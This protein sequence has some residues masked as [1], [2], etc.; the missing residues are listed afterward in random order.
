MRSKLALS[1][2]TM[3][4]VEEIIYYDNLPRGR[5]NCLVQ[6]LKTGN[7]MQIVTTQLNF[8]RN[9]Y[10]KGLCTPEIGKLARRVVGSN[11]KRRI[12]SEQK[13]QLDIRIKKV[14]REL[15]QIKWSFKR[16]G[17]AVRRLLSREALLRYRKLKFE[18]MEK[19][20]VDESNAKKSKLKWFIKKQQLRDH[21]ATRGRE[22]DQRGFEGDLKGIIV[23]ESELREIFGYV[24]D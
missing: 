13:R 15:R 8:L 21:E 18:V 4:L 6:D 3:N 7:K 17:W 9:L 10:D 23:E 19:L 24:E 22:R 11:N 12:K 2:H 16:S 14:E 20:W 1:Q 5:K